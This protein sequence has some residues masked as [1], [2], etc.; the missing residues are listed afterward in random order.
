MHQVTNNGLAWKYPFLNFRVS[1]TMHERSSIQSRGAIA[2][3]NDGS[4]WVSSYTA[5]ARSEPSPPVIDWIA[6]SFVASDV[7]N[8]HIAAISVPA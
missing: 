8:K 4:L 1:E 6:T 2:C 7:I 5:H 3:D